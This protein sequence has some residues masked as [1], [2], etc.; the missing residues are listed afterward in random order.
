MKKKLSRKE[1]ARY[2]AYKNHLPD[3]QVGAIIDACEKELFEELTPRCIGQ[4]FSLNT[5]SFESKDLKR[6]LKDAED[7]WLCV[8]TLGTEADLLLRRWSFENM[9]KAAVG[10]ACCAVMSDQYL[11]FYMQELQEKSAEGEYLL[12][13]FSP[14][15]GDF[16]LSFQRRIL[17]L[18]EAGKRLGVYLTSAGMLVPEKTVTAVIGIS[19]QE[20]EA[21]RA[22]C[23]HCG[24][25][26]CAFRRESAAET[27]EDR[28][29][30]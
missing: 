10:Q 17:D 12:P 13:P 4:R 15:Y 16:S 25:T 23:I 3:R 21:C 1:V 22:S 19:T 2:L 11:D 6:H 8:L 26:D 9:A 29:Q 5:L 14:G 24:K 7:A 27:E 28:N 20:E 30:T 18:T